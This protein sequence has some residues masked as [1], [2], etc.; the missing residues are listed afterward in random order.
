MG[1][2]QQQTNSIYFRLQQGPKPI[3]QDKPD[4]PAV[5]DKQ[6]MEKVT[7]ENGD[8]SSEIPKSS[9]SVG[10]SDGKEK[11]SENTKAP[12]DLNFFQIPCWE[13]TKPSK[14]S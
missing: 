6:D 11:G 14:F 3:I 4:G 13:D 1:K 10:S 9:G 7:E 12:G 8:S 5:T 2:S